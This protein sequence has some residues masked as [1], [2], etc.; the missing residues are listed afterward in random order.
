LNGDTVRSCPASTGDTDT[1]ITS[2]DTGGV[3]LAA[4]QGVKREKDSQLAQLVQLAAEKDREIA[5]LQAEL[6]QLRAEYDGRMM[7]LEMA[8]TEVLQNRSSEKL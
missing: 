5:A 6:P 4:I 7:Q 1:G 8:L 2:I 3:A